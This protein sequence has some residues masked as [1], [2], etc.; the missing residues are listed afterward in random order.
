MKYTITIKRTVT[1]I[2]K[3]RQ[4]YRQI[5]D[6]GNPADGKTVYGYVPAPDIEREKT[7]DVYEQTVDMLDIT[8]VIS[9][10]NGGL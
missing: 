6:S 7:E 5:A 4:E 3:G 10:V 9:A 8:A 1:F 2:E